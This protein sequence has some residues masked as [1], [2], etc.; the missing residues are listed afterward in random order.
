MK[1]KFTELSMAQY[2]GWVWASL[3]YGVFVVGIG[4]VLGIFASP[5]WWFPMLVL[6]LC[7]LA[8]VGLL[9]VYIQDKD[10]A[11]FK[12]ILGLRRK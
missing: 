2:L 12:S 7:W 11:D 1:I 5:D 6:F 8:G 3:V 4:I 10:P 9:R